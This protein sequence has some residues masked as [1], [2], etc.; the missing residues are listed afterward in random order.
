MITE[1]QI[2]DLKDEAIAIGDT[3]QVSLCRRALRGDVDALAE[4]ERVIEHNKAQA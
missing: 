1:R 4:C 2:E 3:E